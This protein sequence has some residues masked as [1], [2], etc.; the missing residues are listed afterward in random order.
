[1]IYGTLDSWEDAFAIFAAVPG[2]YR[3]D[4]GAKV[5]AIAHEGRLA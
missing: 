3:A 4:T 1:L 2:S 5:F